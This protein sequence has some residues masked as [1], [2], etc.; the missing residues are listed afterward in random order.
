MLEGARRPGDVRAALLGDLY[1]EMTDT[2]DRGMDQHPLPGP[3][4][5]GVDEGL[6]GGE[7]GQR[8]SGRLDV[9]VPGG[10]GGERAGGAGDVLGVGAGPVRVG[11]HA[12]HLVTGLEE[13]DAVADLHHGAGDVPSRGSAV[14]AAGSHCGRGA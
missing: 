5:P 14:G 3:E 6:P 13:G 7:R 1:G 9:V 10:L 11:E 12:E 4:A 8:Q 2:A